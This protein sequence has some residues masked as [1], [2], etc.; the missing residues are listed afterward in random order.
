MDTTLKD[1][2]LKGSNSTVAVAVSGRRAV[3]GGMEGDCSGP[4]E[5]APGPTYF[6]VRTLA[7]QLL[8][9]SPRSRQAALLRPT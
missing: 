1:Y 4:M 2:G 9:L 3:V 5:T 8:V 6:V 7:R